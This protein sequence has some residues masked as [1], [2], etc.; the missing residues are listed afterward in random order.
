MGI[1]QFFT[2]LA[3]VDI[4]KDKGVSTQINKTIK[5]NYFYFDFNSVVYNVVGQIE[6][7]LNNILYEIILFVNN[8]IDTIDDSIINDIRLWGFKI[9]YNK[10]TML[11]NYVLF[12]K[13]IDNNIINEKIKENIKHILKFTDY[14]DIKKIFISFDG[15]PNMGK[16]IEQ[17]KRRYNGTVTN[18]LKKKIYKKEYEKFSYERKLYEKHKY[19]YDRTNIIAAS[20]SLK[21][22]NDELLNYIDDIKKLCP[23]LT[24]YIISGPDIRGEGEK[25]I[26]EH[27]IENKLPGDYIIFSPDADLIILS[28]LLKIILLDNNINNSFSIIRYEQM[29]GVYGLIDID[30]FLNN[31]KEYINNKIT[32]N[33]NFD[34]TFM[35]ISYLYTFFGN[36]FIPRIEAINPK[37]DLLFILDRYI[38]LINQ[39]NNFG[40]INK[41]NNSY[42][43][44]YASFIQ[45]FNNLA[46]YEVNMLRDK[47]IVKNYN[48]FFLQKN[49]KSTS[50]FEALLNYT[51]NAN[52]IF[53]AVI[54]IKNNN[55]LFDKILNKLIKKIK[56]IDE[57][58][59]LFSKLENN[60]KDVD[61]SGNLINKLKTIISVLLT[62]NNLPSFYLNPVNQDNY[63]FNN[64]IFPNKHIIVSQYDIEAN[65]LERKIGKYKYML[66]GFDVEIG[67]VK[68]LTNQFNYVLETTPIQKEKIVYYKQL[69]NTSQN[70]IIEEYIKGMFWIFDFYINRNQNKI[71]SQYI[72]TWFYKYHF[73]PLLCDVNSYLKQKNI[74]NILKQLMLYVSTQNFIKSQY[75]LTGFEHRMYVTPINKLTIPNNYIKFSKNK[76][77][78]PDVNE[79]IDQIWKGNGNKYIDCRNVLFI[80]KCNLLTVK[81]VS[82]YK[83][84]KELHKTGFK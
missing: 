42:H 27:I 84:K 83:F 65:M 54:N 39:K 71:N 45:L 29:T 23:N 8:K 49:I 69:F 36:D 67:C 64:I 47:Y 38:D 62:K 55:N 75:F 10:K 11:N 56:N 78:F 17:K 63:K 59:L 52:I 57:F 41:Y 3:K 76:E 28:V 50:I 2:N 32:K 1:E 34:R 12:L 25:K 58:I 15:V 14:K 35:D 81:H 33:I 79:I 68:L 51:Y 43:I 73:T 24:E 48:T 20:S 30:I 9:D 5:C 7:E 82:F 4:F 80:N 26:M 37:K 21:S 70:N 22:L 72:S 74:K 31:M 60:F 18:E 19:S 66:N 46:K 77:I 44:D 40:I 16:I 53:D 61:I 6:N 13:N